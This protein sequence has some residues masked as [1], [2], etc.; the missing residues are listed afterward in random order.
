MNPTSPFPADWNTPPPERLPA[1]TIWPATLAVGATL[2]AWGLISTWIL[3]AAGGVLFTLAIAGWI[4]ELRH[5]R[6]AS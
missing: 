1:P 5:E 6:N 3:S 4:H 2:L